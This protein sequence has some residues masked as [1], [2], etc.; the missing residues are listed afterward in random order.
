ME[1]GQTYLGGAQSCRV[2][3][4][5]V[6]TY[7][8]PRHV[9]FTTSTPP[10]VSCH[11]IPSNVTDVPGSHGPKQSGSVIVPTDVPTHTSTISFGSHFIFFA[12]GGVEPSST[13]PFA[14]ADDITLAAVEDI[15]AVV[16]SL[17]PESV[18]FCLLLAT[19]GFSSMLL[20]VDFVCF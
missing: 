2:Q 10:S 19:V 17:L 16:T 7:V 15:V 13:V 18:N 14:M 6:P 3:S 8:L 5:N 20:S 1:R 4:S 9:T 12:G 11:T